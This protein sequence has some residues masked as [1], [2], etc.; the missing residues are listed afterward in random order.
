MDLTYYIKRGSQNYEEFYH[1]SEDKINEDEIYA[2]QLC[3]FFTKDGKEYELNSNEM[4]EDSEV[5]VL[6]EKGESRPFLHEKN[7]NGLGIHLEFR[8]YRKKGEMQLLSVK[9]LQ[10]HW[11]VIRYLLKDVVDVPEHGQMLRGSAEID[12]DRQVYVLYVTKI[13]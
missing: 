1:Y 6:I 9:K 7:Y 13:S 5:L 10:N 4:I 2:R 11:E 12:E 8:L 3:E